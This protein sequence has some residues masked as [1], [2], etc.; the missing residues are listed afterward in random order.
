MKGQSEQ[1]SRMEVALPGDLVPANP[2]LRKIDKAI[3]CNFIHDKVKHLYCE[4]NGRPAI[5]PVVLFKML[6]IGYPLHEKCAATVMFNKE[7]AGI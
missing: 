2:L 3:D 6:F 7:T 1:Q 5:E 4:D